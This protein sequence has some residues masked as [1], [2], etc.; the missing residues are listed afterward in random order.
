MSGFLHALSLGEEADLRR[1]EGQTYASGAV[2]LMTVHGAKGLE[3]P[4]VFLAG[5]TAGSFPLERERHVADLAE[6]RRL[7]FVGMTRAREELILTASN[8][9]S[10]FAQSLPG[11]VQREVLRQHR[12]QQGKQLTLF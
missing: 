11:T 2:H 5:L 4:V 9:P 6:E 1:A 10:E 12:P 7:F 8:P 3:F